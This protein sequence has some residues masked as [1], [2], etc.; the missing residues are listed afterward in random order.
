MPPPLLYVKGDE[1]FLQK[2]SV[3][4]VGSRQASAAGHKLARQ[5]AAELGRAGYVVTSGLARGIDGAAHEAALATG[6]IAVVAGGIDII[7]PPEHA[8]LTEQIATRGCIVSEM[9]P[10]FVPRAKEFPRRNRIIAG[11]A[12]GV[13]V[14]EAARRSGT[15]VTARLAAEIGREVFA[16]PG[17]PLDPRAEGTNQL[18]KSGATFV[19]EAADVIS[20]LSPMLRQP[21]PHTY[22]APRTRET[23]PPEEATDTDRRRVLDALGPH[24]TDIDEIGR[25]AGLSARAVRLVLIEL[26]LAGRIERHGQHLVSLL[27]GPA[28]S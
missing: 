3:A 13:V 21:A 27:S 23:P 15:L 9:P 11:I 4:I 19:T 14:I 12:L 28:A 1:A 18:L 22:D 26:D 17:H 16:L 25:A 7:Y 20:T 24:P 8:D 5:F 6:T 2:P 10:G